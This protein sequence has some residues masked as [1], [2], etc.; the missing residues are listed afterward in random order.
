MCPPPPLPYPFYPSLRR[1]SGVTAFGG[2]SYILFRSFLCNAVM[3]ITKIMD[4]Y[5]QTCFKWRAKSFVFYTGKILEHENYSNNSGKD[6]RK[7]KQ[8]MDGRSV[9]DLYDVLG[10]VA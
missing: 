8:C 6:N 7:R 1:D 4:L 10:S 3:M 9:I 5:D 2:D